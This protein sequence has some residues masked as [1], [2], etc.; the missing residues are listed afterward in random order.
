MSTIVV[1]HA[2]DRY[3]SGA[4]NAEF[5]DDRWKALQIQRLL[6]PHVRLQGLRSYA[7]IGCGNG[8]VLANL[9]QGLRDHGAPLGRAVGYDIA[10]IQDTAALDQQGIVFRQADFLDTEDTYD[11]I[12]LNDVIEHV[13]EPTRFLTA[14]SDRAK[15]LAL[16]IPL[17]DRLSVHLTNQ[18]NYR[19]QSVG[20]L[21]FWNAS[22]AINLLTGAGLTPLACRFTPGFLAP[23]GRQRPLQIAAL[24][25]RWLLWTISPCIASKTLGGVSLAVI[26]RGRLG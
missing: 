8:G 7:D 16:H 1:D 26:C 18:Y 25:M 4:Y 10:P 22:S 2:Q 20:H 17:D 24:P 12:T 14:L 5:G 19:L 3:K 11:L 15:Y 21:S 23:S 6:L 13:T 9:V